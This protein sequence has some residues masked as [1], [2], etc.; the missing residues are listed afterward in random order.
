M[1][2]DSAENSKTQ[3]HQQILFAANRIERETKQI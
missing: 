3:R 2:P 1:K